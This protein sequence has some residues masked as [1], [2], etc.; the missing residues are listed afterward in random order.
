MKPT[1]RTDPTASGWS[2]APIPT[3]W[4]RAGEPRARVRRIADSSDSTTAVVEWECTPGRF[5]WDFGAE[6]ETVV[7]L[8]GEVCLR[9]QDGSERTIVPGDI[10]H[11]EAGALVDWEVR[12]TVRKAA[13]CRAPLGTLASL[14][15]RLDRRFSRLRRRGAAPSGGVSRTG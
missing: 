12:S 3:D 10:V 14:G 6:D 11:F 15:H 9:W 4:I 2:D 5:V 7:V 8:A 13:M 1:V